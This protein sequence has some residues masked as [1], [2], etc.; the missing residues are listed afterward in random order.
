[1]RRKS[2]VKRDGEGDG[3]DA[4]GGP[5][6]IFSATAASDLAAG[7]DGGGAEQ[8]AGAAQLGGVIVRAAEAREKIKTVGFQAA[9]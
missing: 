6:G 1:M 4:R 3:E 7:K 5:P 8:S 2:L 9:S